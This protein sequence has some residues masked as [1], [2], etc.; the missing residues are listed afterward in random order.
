M[1]LTTI[2]MRS[3]AGGGVWMGAVTKPA[4]AGRFRSQGR[5]LRAVPKAFAMAM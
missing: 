2:E 5:L 3:C 1:P 4:G